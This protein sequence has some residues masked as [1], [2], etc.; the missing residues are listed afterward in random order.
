MPKITD[1]ALWI[2]RFHFRKRIHELAH[3]A[4]T[5]KG[6]QE[7][8]NWVISV[9]IGLGNCHIVLL[10]HPRFHTGDPIALVTNAMLNE[11]DLAGTTQFPPSL[12][13]QRPPESRNHSC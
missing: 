7:A 10:S 1:F 3:M 4:I 6:E 8:K 13:Q 12:L 11:Y 5:V 2:L 9:V